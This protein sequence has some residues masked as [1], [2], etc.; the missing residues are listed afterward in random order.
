MITAHA[1]VTN[2]HAKVFKPDLHASKTTMTSEM[3]SYSKSLKHYTEKESYSFSASISSVLDDYSLGK[4][5]LV[6]YT[7]AYSSSNRQ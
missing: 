1:T 3:L 5:V 2:M 6:P 7:N 4:K